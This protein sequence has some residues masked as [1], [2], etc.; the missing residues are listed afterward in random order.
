MLQISRY[1]TDITLCYRYHTMLQI[2]RYV[3]DIM[4]CYRYHAMLQISRYVTDITLCYRY[5]AI[6]QISH[7]VTDIML[8]Y[9]YHAI[10]QISRYV[11]DVT[12][13]YRYH[14]QWKYTTQRLIFVVSL[15]EFLTTDKLLLWQEA[16]SN[17]SLTTDRNEDKL[18][19]DLED[20]LHGL[21]SL[22][23]ELV[24]IY[25]LFTLSACFCV[26]FISKGPV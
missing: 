4:L 11:T 21:I 2:S 10:L 20:Y 12:L 26:K 22:C 8:C 24:R 25:L 15:V 13:C 7:Y 18:Y 6:L 9:R 5:H 16:A 23:N 1:V 14:D 19:L 3:T 17:L